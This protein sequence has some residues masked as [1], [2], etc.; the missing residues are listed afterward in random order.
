L[1]HRDIVVMG[2]SAGGLDVLRQILSDLP[3]DLPAAVL[4]HVSADAPGLLATVLGRRCALPVE[5]AR[6]GAP[7]RSGRVWPEKR[8]AERVPQEEPTP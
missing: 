6:D 4:V 1:H 7:I 3:P 5:E 2:A 8:S